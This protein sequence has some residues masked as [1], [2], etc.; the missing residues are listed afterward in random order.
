MS[1]PLSFTVEKAL[2]DDQGVERARACRLTLQPSDEMGKVLQDVNGGKA[3]EI[4]TPVFM[5][6]GTQGTVKAISTDELH[7]MNAQII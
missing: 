7:K 5:P 2:T 3:H 4:L 1:S 6:V